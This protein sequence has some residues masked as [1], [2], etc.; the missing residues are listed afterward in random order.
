MKAE[1]LARGKSTKHQEYWLLVQKSIDNKLYHAVLW[2]AKELPHDHSSIE[3]P[4]EISKIVIWEPSGAHFFLPPNKPPSN[5]IM[6]INSK[7]KFGLYKGFE[8]GIVYAFDIA[9]F[10]WMIEN[11]EHFC[12]MDIDLLTNTGV[13]RSARKFSANREMGVS[14]FDKFMCEFES[15]QLLSQ[16]T[17]ILNNEIKLKSYIIDLNNTKVRQINPPQFSK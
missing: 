10:S 4:F 15:I 12:V 6:T 2:I 8:I 9:Y 16:S 5:G 7:L 17:K 3:I 11:I 13:F 1:I 14:N